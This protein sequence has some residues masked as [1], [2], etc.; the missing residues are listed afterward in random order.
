MFHAAA[1]PAITPTPHKVVAA[2]N[3]KRADSRVLPRNH[4]NLAGG[5]LDCPTVHLNC[6]IFGTQAH[7]QISP[8]SILLPRGTAKIRGVAS[9]RHQS[10]QLA[11]GLHACGVQ[12]R[13][14]RGLRRESRW[15]QDM[16]VARTPQRQSPW[17]RSRPCDVRLVEK[18]NAD[19]LIQ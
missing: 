5:Q 19:L 15:N 8:Q 16:G 14:S 13:Q 12:L 4:Y 2:T 9:N 10:R 17:L 7:E 6:L 3:P 11:I 1:R 18:V